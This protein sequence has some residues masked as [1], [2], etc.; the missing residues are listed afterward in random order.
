MGRNLKLKNVLNQFFSSIF[1]FRKWITSMLLLVD[2]TKRWK[3]TVA[4]SNYCTY[5]PRE[6]SCHYLSWIGNYMDFFVDPR[7]PDR[8]RIE[9]ISNNFR[10]SLN[11]NYCTYAPR[12]YCCNYL[13]QIGNYSK[14]FLPGF[15]PGI[16]NILE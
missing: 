12:E 4:Y 10:F 5:A 1:W 11:F 8:N 13:N 9:K 14:F 7:L 6:C 2:H 16:R 15:D 3:W